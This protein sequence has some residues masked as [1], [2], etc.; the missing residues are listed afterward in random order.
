M[1]V[2]RP[3]HPKL[4]KNPCEA[5]NIPGHF[6]RALNKVLFQIIFTIF[7]V[8]KGVDY[9]SCASPPPPPLRRGLPKIKDGSACWIF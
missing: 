4:D 5:T 3:E 9:T 2:F 6:P 1:V 8:E 7:R